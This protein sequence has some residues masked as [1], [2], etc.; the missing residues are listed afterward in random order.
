MAVCDFQQKIYHAGKS[1]VILGKKVTIVNVFQASDLAKI[2][3]SN[4]QCMIMFFI[5]FI[6][7]YVAQR[8]C[9]SVLYYIW[10]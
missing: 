1:E 8:N 6:F 9:S 2:F 10:G 5:Y 7:S 3:I 4:F